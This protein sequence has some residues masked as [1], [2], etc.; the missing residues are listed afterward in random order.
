MLIVFYRLEVKLLALNKKKCDLQAQLQQ[1]HRTISHLRSTLSE[2][3]QIKHEYKS[4]LNY[5]EVMMNKYE[6]RNYDLEEHEVDLK[7]RLEML[8]YSMPV[9]LMWNMWRLMQVTQI[10]CTDTT[11]TVSNALV[12]AKGED[13]LGIRQTD[14]SNSSLKLSLEACPPCLARTE[15]SRLQDTEQEKQKILTE[16]HE[17][18]KMW[19]VTEEQLQSRLQVLETQVR[20]MNADIQGYKESEVKYK[21]TITELENELHG[22]KSGL[23]VLDVNNATDL[24]PKK[25]TVTQLSQNQLFECQSVSCEKTECTKKLQELVQS[26]HDMK[27]Y[28]NQLE[29]AYTETLQQA[30]KMWSEME[31]SYK[32]QISN[33][34]HNE[35]VMREQVKKLE[36][37][38]AKL[39]QAFQHDEENEILMEKIQNMERHGKR[40]VERIHILEAEK[41]QLIEETNNVREVLQSLQMELDKTKEMVAR[42]LKEELLKE[43]KLSKSLQDEISALEK[44][45]RDRSNAQ[46]TQVGSHVTCLLH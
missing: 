39:R 35:A 37:S 44:E 29:R 25:K 31:N 14:I 38:K 19:L 27:E 3:E 41:H 24:A 5:L 1:Q 36:E 30:D 13:H 40:S 9:L 10:S 16:T 8:E 17:A 45:S 22:M 20:F 34:E 32:K 18:E 23:Q 28:I 33:A 11:A 42:P 6:Q 12:K 15:S 46:Q 7:H 26:E 2:S 4:Q 21:K 43:R